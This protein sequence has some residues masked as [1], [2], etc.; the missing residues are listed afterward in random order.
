MIL[1]GITKHE[2]SKALAMTNKLFDGNV[3][4]NNYSCMNAKGTRHRVTL[5][6][7]NS[8][9]PGARLGFHRNNDGNRRKLINLCWHGYGTFI[10]NIFE[11]RADAKVSNLI[12]GK[13]DDV[14][15]WYWHDRQIGS[16]MDPMW[17]SDACE[18]KG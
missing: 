1:S 4:I 2:I 15:S 17:F 8:S 7:R 18:C 6:V 10:D 3:I 12:T 14:D 5:R 16:M 9:G 11:V 13:M